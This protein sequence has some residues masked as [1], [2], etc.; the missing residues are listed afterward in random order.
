MATRSFVVDGIT[1]EMEERDMQVVER[2]INNLSSELSAAQSELTGLR[3]SSQTE[4]AT[5]R[6]ETA[7]AVG[8]VQTKDAEI[9]TL[10]QQLADA[11]L[12]PQDLD[13]LVAERSQTLAKA[14]TLVGDALVVEGKTDAEIRRQVVDAKLGEQAKGWNDDMVAASFNTLTATVTLDSGDKQNTNDFQR[15]G[16]ALRNSGT[17]PVSKSYKEYEDGLANRWKTA[18]VRQ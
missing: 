3:S 18:G 8:Q 14:K 1:V 15:L 16:L 10:K 2:R 17:D 5:S 4:L 11:K 9:A 6:T 13:K 12:K 7:N